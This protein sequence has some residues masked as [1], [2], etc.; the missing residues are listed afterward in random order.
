MTRRGLFP[1]MAAAVVVPP[2]LPALAAEV[3]PVRALFEEWKRIYAWCEA[4]GITDGERS[5]RV[6]VLCQHELALY[7]EPSRD[8]DDLALKMAV[9][10]ASD[11]SLGV[12]G[13]DTAVLR[14]DVRRFFAERGEKLPGS[15]RD[16]IH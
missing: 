5:K 6:D 8:T 3:S 7:A 4:S 10:A 16:D 11:F 13:E 2:C 12:D 14:P 9:L 15:H 1:A